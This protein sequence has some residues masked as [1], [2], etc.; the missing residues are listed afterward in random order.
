MEEKTV[1]LRPRFFVFL[2]VFGERKGM[3]IKKVCEMAEKFS[4]R[5]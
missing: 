4:K 3:E 5:Y 1:G 2:A